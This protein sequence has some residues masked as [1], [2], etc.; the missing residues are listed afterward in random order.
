MTVVQIFK[1]FYEWTGSEKDLSLFNIW[2]Q[3]TKEQTR[4]DMSVPTNTAE[5]QEVE[6][7]EEIIVQDSNENHDEMNSPVTTNLEIFD[8]LDSQGNQFLEEVFIETQNI[9]IP[10]V[11]DVESVNTILKEGGILLYTE[12]STSTATNESDVAC[13]ENP[14]PSL[15]TPQK[16][17]QV[18]LSSGELIP[19]PFK[20]TLFWPEPSKAVNKVRRSKEKIPSVATSA[21]WVAYHKKKEDKKRYEERKKMKEC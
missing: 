5:Y 14:T 10:I 9:D 15:Q 1:M 19:S 21:Q 4:I 2:K 20:K 13:K 17:T 7:T 11:E 12:P 6:T 3:M 8:N 16:E 18:L